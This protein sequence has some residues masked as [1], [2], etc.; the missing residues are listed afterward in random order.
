MRRLLPLLLLAVAAGWPAAAHAG[1]A[2]DEMARCADFGAKRPGSAAGYAMGDRIAERF[3]AAGLETS[4]ESFHMPVWQ[5]GATQMAIAA[6]PGAGTSYPTETFPY[7]GTGDVKAPVVDLGNGGPS[8]YDGKDVKGKVVLVD[9]SDTY[10][11]TVQ[12]Q[13][14]ADHGAAAMLLIS[15]SPD[16]LIQTGTVK[17]AQRPPAAIPG[18]T[19]GSAD[20]ARLRA[21]MAGGTVTLAIKARGARVD[22]VARNVIGVRRG[23]THPDKYVVVAGHYD[24]WYAG[25]F[26]NCTAVGSLLAL[27]EPA[28]NPNPAYTTIYIG[29]DA[30]EPG[31]NGSYTWLAEHQDLVPNIVLNV[32]LEETAND[33]PPQF[34]LTTGAPGLLTSI[35]ASAL[36]AGFTPVIAPVT[37]YR[38]TS[39]GVIATDLEGFYGS[40]VQGVSTASLSDYYHTTAD[41]AEKINLGDL[42]R[43]TSYLRNLVRNVQALPPEALTLREVPAIT[44]SAPATADAGAA[45]PV[46][47]TVTGPAGAPVT[48][49]RPTVLADQRDNWAIAEGEAQELG[50]GRYR[51]ELPAGAADADI[52]KLRVQISDTG[53]LSVGFAKVDQRGGGL[54]PASKAA[55]SSR[56]VIRVHVKRRLGKGRRI[57]KLRVRAA[58]GKAKVV[59]RSH[60]QFVVRVD[61]RGVAKRPV[62]VR[63]TAKTNRGKRL[64]Q[65]RTFRTCT[66]KPR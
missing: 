56:R 23:T 51:Y 25:A 55:C 52:T 2:S 20:G 53:Y 58:A 37:A 47:V 31:L 65:T 59:K 7:S 8:D 40:G 48:G 36:T 17:D 10:H 18:V 66:P 6:G 5:S 61:L 64:R 34:A 3:R 13:Q 63:L 14:A 39:G 15:A 32:N 11:R 45:V 42:E 50:G 26:D 46:D 62:R 30:E 54:L 16:N 28:A 1:T 60:R 33:G 29:W 22:G 12:I 57:V 41:T 44:V 35:G 21:Q 24:S 19:V 38:L 27:A 4:L 43:V 49:A 9:R